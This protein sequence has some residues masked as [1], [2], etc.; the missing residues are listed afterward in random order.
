MEIRSKREFFDLWR[1]GVLG[2][3]TPLYSTLDEAFAS[4]ERQI[5]FREIGKGGGGAWAR[6]KDRL[7]ARCIYAM[8]VAQ[9]RK[10]IMDSNVP[11]ERSTLQGEVCRTFRGLEG[12]LA[13]GYG[14]PP[15]RISMAQGLL[16]PVTAATILVLTRKYMDPS[17]QEDLDALLELYPEATIE[18]TCFDCDVGNIPGRNTLFWEVRNY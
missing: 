7:E 3:R 16:K 15:M 13:V 9:G 8:W 17:S 6:S 2:N 18:F 4:G 1:A 5:G 10:F 14:L 11:N 12:Y